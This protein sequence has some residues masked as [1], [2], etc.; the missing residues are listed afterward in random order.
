MVRV[1]FDG[2]SSVDN[3][4]F[5]NIDNTS[6]T[7]VTPLVGTPGETITISGVNFPTGTADFQVMFGVVPATVADIVGT[8]TTT[9]IKVKVP[10][11]AVR[12]GGQQVGVVI[13][14]VLNNYAGGTFRVIRVPV[15]ET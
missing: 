10:Q 9:Q 11:A 5:E 1:V 15:I 8:P 7:S 3:I 6:V 2:Q 12:G 13:Q 4:L 14:G